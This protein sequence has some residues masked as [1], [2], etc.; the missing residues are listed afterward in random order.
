MGAEPSACQSLVEIH[1]HCPPETG[2]RWSR[3]GEI[4]EYAA[5]E[6]SHCRSPSTTSWI[7]QFFSRLEP[8]GRAPCTASAGAASGASARPRSSDDGAAAF[9][10]G[11][12]APG[13]TQQTRRDAVSGGPPRSTC[14]PRHWMATGRHRLR[15]SAH[16][17]AR[18]ASWALVQI[19]R[20]P[21]RWRP[22]PGTRRLRLAQLGAE[23]KASAPRFRWHLPPGNSASR[24][25]C[26]RPAPGGSQSP[27]ADQGLA[28]DG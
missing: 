23:G 28:G 3:E 4:I 1:G 22:G 15:A 24:T 9:D 21:C 12:R 16:E 11:R 25:A 19:E 10:R 6:Q 8:R 14:R 5:G 17:K 13:P 2:P 18:R 7:S 20:A 27:S 26:P